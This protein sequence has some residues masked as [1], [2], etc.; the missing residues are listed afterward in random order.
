MPPSAC[1][2]VGVTSSSP[3]TRGVKP[4]RPTLINRC[5]SRGPLPCSSCLKNTNVSRQASILD[6]LRP[7][8]QCRVIVVGPTQPQIA[9]VRRRHEWN[10]Q[11]V[12]G[13]GDAQRHAMIAEQS[14]DFVVEPRRV[15]KLK[16]H[17][18]LWRHKREERTQPR[19]VLLHGGRQ[20]K[21]QWSQT[22]RQRPGG[23]EQS[24]QE[25]VFVFEPLQMRDLPRRFE[26]EAEAGRNLAGPLFQDR[27]FGHAK[28]VLLISTVRKRSL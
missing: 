12:V 10:F 9:P 24:R 20:L 5:A 21:Q 11:I 19:Y 4:T 18:L 1:A 13:V 7:R 2:G 16:C 23:F 6:P 25:F 3:G 22:L 28:N 15:T 17:A 14:E 26:R 27:G 8:L